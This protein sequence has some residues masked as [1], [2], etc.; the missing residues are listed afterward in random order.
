[1]EDWLN[2]IN[3]EKEKDLMALETATN[4]PEVKDVIVKPDSAKNHLTNQATTI[5]FCR[6]IDTDIL[7]Q[8]FQLIYWLSDYAVCI[9]FISALVLLFLGLESLLPN[10][11]PLGLLGGG[12]I[13]DS[14]SAASLSN[15]LLFFLPGGRPRRFC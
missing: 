10:G 1:M 7:R 15:V 13:P 12:R 14:R 5:R 6:R 9:L 2:L 11:R 4:I 3:A 8:F